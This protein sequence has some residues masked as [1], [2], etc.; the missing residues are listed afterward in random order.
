MWLA[1]CSSS[2]EHC[3]G[4][5]QHRLPSRLISIGHGVVK[6]VVTASLP[7]PP[8]YATLSYCWGSEPFTMLTQDNLELFMDHITLDEL[9]QTFRDAINASRQL[10]I[11]FIWIDALC[12]IQKE[13]SNS[14]WATESGHMSAI[15]SGTFVTLAASIATSVQEGFLHRSPHHRGGFVARVTTSDYC[16]V[17]DFHSGDPHA[18]STTKTHLATRAWAFQE[19]LLSPRTIYFGDAGLFW[20]CR[21]CISSEFLL[22]GSPV[23][24]ERFEAG[25]ENK[26]WDWGEIVWQYSKAKLTYTSDRLPALSGVVARQQEI[27]GDQYLAGMWRESLV[28][29]LQWTRMGKKSRRPGWRAPTWSWAAID[30]EARYWS[31]WQYEYR[32]P[33]FFI[34]V[35]DAWATPSGPDPFGA[36]A[37]GELTLSC[38]HL[39]RGQLITDG[40]AAEQDVDL[41][42]MGPGLVRFPVLLDCLLEA[43]TPDD[44]GVHLLPIVEDETGLADTDEETGEVLWEQLVIRGLVLRACGDAKGLQHFQRI[45]GFSV[46]NKMDEG[47]EDSYQVF[48][49]A[50]RKEDLSVAGTDPT[51][52]VSVSEDRE[53]RFVIVI[54]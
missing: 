46:R 4:K 36:V 22:D 2:H 30:G 3:H 11:D 5:K 39:V 17:Q 51:Q 6:L 19:R 50:L 32:R 54:K 49:D 1:R 14:D 8:R 12:I 24:H 7:K 29:E 13:E 42:Q 28:T 35:L 25:S 16:T 44:Y 48:M 23:L 43:S 47:V 41:V 38:T 20:E 40:S 27:N 18:E 31:T 26:A 53:R 15:Y 52:T 10:G 21:S 33:Q 37:D 34:Q 45:G 9:P